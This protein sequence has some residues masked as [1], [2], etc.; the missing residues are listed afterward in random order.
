MPALRVQIPQV[1]DTVHYKSASIG[2]W[3]PAHIVATNTRGAVQLNVKAGFWI[4]VGQQAKALR[5]R[6]E[7]LATEWVTAEALAEKAQ[8]EREAARE[9][10]IAA[11]ALVEQAQ[12]D[13]AAAKK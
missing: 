3:I 4:E 1:G 9:D 12:K 7:I 11:E 13:V 10:K 8:K 2:R 6:S 5:P